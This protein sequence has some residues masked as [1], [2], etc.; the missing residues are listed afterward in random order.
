M[1]G[2]GVNQDFGLPV[3]RSCLANE[4]IDGYLTLLQL[5]SLLYA[6]FTHANHERT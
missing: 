6:G 4:R 1:S 3:S 2:N 5:P